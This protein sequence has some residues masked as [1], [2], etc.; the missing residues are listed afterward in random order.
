MSKNKIGVEEKK[1]MRCIICQS[2]KIIRFLEAK[3]LDNMGSSLYHYLKCESCGLVFLE[4]KEGLVNLQ[5]V[6]KESGYYSREKVR[7]NKAVDFLMRFFN[8]LRYKSVS[9]N[10][11]NKKGKLLDI[12]CGKGKFLVEARKDGWEVFGI[13]PTKRSSDIAISRYNLNVIQKYLS[14][15]QFESESFDVVTMWHVFEHILNPNNV[16]QIAYSWLKYNGLLVIAVPNIGSIQASFGKDLWF[17]LDP[18]RHLY[19]FSPKTLKLILE[20]NGFT[21]KCISYFY[22]ELNYFSLI[23][24]FLNKV[25]CSPNF[26]FNFSKGNKKG[27]PKSP[28]IFT[29]DII[30]TILSFALLG[31]PLLVLSIMEGIYKKGGS[32]VVFAKK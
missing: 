10:F 25:G 13:E 3:S 19:H 1:N 11:R 16:L 22:S 5:D 21:I 18:P 20:K 12:G 30:I 23:Q 8:R 28:F 26:I 24:T 2:D 17:N 7:L 9:K 29:R 15:E 6:Y 31:F 14:L 27:L 32:I 4:E